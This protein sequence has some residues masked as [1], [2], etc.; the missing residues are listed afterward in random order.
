MARSAAA[1]WG[2]YQAPERSSRAAPRR[3]DTASTA[4]A[5][6]GD[7]KRCGSLGCGQQA[8][9]AQPE[10]KEPRMGWA[11][12]A[13]ELNRACMPILLFSTP[14][15][16][17]RATPWFCPA[18]SAGRTTG[19]WVP[20]P[21]MC[22]APHIIALL[23]LLCAAPGLPRCTDVSRATLAAP[24]GGR[25]HRQVWPAARLSRRAR[26]RQAPLFPL[27]LPVICDGSSMED[28]ADR[29]NRKWR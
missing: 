21:M 20:L 8:R 2:P 28:D 14:K 22:I 13:H 5:A 4:V 27:P 24:K 12:P 18:R 29:S 17:L 16:P 9:W 25:A 6:I 1:M 7:E 3:R 23:L 15:K 26:S 10:G 11:G 19:M